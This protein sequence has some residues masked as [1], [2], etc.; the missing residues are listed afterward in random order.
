MD[1]TR[2]VATYCRGNMKLNFKVKDKL[3]LNFD[4]TGIY[5]EPDESPLLDAEG[6]I[7]RALKCNPATI[8][9]SNLNIAQD[10]TVE[11]FDI[12]LANEVGPDESMTESDAI[13][14]VSISGRNPKGNV[15]PSAVQ[16]SSWNPFPKW[17][18]G[19][20]IPIGISVGTEPGK[21]F[22]IIISEGQLDGVDDTGDRKGKK[23]YKLS[24]TCLGRT[25][26]YFDNEVSFWQY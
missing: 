26:K 20:A 9:V 17:A 22:R 5:H 6:T 15:D 11:S 10:C 12:D 2:K 1:G 4:F 8:T 3:K 25:K 14:S 16:L 19:I 24:F 18:G 23:V 21:R 7:A 13:L